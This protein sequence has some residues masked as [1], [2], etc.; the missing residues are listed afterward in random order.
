MIK[1]FLSVQLDDT[2][3]SI[4]LLLLRIS[5]GALMIPHGYQKLIKFAEYQND[6]M[7]FMGLG[8]SVSLSLTILAEFFCAILLV[9]GL[10]SRIS[11]IPLIV[12]MLVAVFQAH[13]A[14]IFGD[15][16]HAFLYLVAYLALFI[17]GPGKY[18]LDA[19]IFKK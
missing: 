7:N 9:A 16:E 13:Q 18:S 4:A 5:A 11:L 1:K 2:K 6:F 10:L 8:T 19:L 12:V 17:A 15:G 3:T 14:E